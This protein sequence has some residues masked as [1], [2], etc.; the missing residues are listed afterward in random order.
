L[1]KC[2]SFLLLFNV[3]ARFLSLSF[4]L[5]RVNNRPPAMAT[6]RRTRCARLEFFCSYVRRLSF[7]AMFD[8]SL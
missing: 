4:L 6:L 3:C 5:I 1:K 7:F 2:L 8:L